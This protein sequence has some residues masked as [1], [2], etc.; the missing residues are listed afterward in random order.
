MKGQGGTFLSFTGAEGPAHIF[1][2][3]SY[4]QPIDVGFFSKRGDGPPVDA[5]LIAFIDDAALYKGLDALDST[6]L[7][8]MA[9]A[10]L[11][12][13]LF[14]WRLSRG[15]KRSLD[16]IGQGIAAMGRGE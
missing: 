3:A 4:D 14:G 13:F 12:T 2:A 1:V 10:L 16:T 9:G 11:L 7:A 8:G 5:S 6:I 15:Y